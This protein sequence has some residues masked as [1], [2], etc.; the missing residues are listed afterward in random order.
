MTQEMSIYD[1]TD[2]LINN[3]YRILPQNCGGKIGSGSFGEI[4]KAID[5]TNGEV[6]FGFY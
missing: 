1:G 3:K 5:I 6:R 2:F 4:Y